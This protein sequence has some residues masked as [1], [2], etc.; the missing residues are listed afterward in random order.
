[1]NFNKY[2]HRSLISL[3]AI[4]LIGLSGSAEAI[5][6]GCVIAKTLN[7]GTVTQNPY[8]FCEIGS[9]GTKCTS[10]ALG[11]PGAFS[12]YG[13]VG[14]PTALCP[15]GQ[16][17]MTLVTGNYAPQGL[18]VYP[19]YLVVGVTYAPPGPQSFVTYSTAGTVGTTVSNSNSFSSMTTVS[20]SGTIGPLHGVDGG[21]A[22]AT[23]SAAISQSSTNSTSTTLS[24]QNTSTT[25]TSGPSNANSPVNH[26]YD[27]VWVWLNPVAQYLVTTSPVN[28]VVFEGF[29]FDMADEP[30]ADIWP[31]YVGELNG[32]FAMEAGTTAE[33]ARSWASNGKYFPAGDSPAVTAADYANILAAD[34]FTNAGYSFAVNNSASPVTTTDG[35][36][37]LAS[38][39]QG[40]APQIDYVPGLTQTYSLATSNSST[41]GS[42]SSNSLGTT[43]SID[44]SETSSTSFAT[45]TSELKISN[46]LTWTHTQ[47][48]SVMKSTMY[49]NALSISGPCTTPAGCTP[50]YAGPSV[51]D[52]YQDN[53]WG[54]FYFD[55]IR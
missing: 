47:N 13:M 38:N 23:T 2:F 18:N 9:Y 52:V 16:G 42:G 48:A 17:Y 41:T 53:I 8:Q 20:T 55:A 40:A 31:V 37:S 15:Q 46:Q 39:A 44:L 51:F 50:A 21:K 1:M 45:F 12:W 6:G 43:F 49:T 28:S 10:I 7:A 5:T 25:K 35:R 36:F 30:E 27:I 14:T 22:T 34:P 54:T 19:R 3:G 29:G 26:D 4:L 33:F 24:V 32:H 11:A